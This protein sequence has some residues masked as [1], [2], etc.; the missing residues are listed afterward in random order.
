MKS[1]KIILRKLTKLIAIFLV[2]SFNKNIYSKSFTLEEAIEYGVSNNK[3]LKI[4]KLN[5][6]KAE[7][8]VKEAKG[9]AFPSL[10]FTT[11]YYHYIQKPI[12][13]FPDF[14]AL[15]N[16]STY[17]ILFKEGLVQQDNTKLLPMGMIK[18]SF[19]LN[20]QFESK[21]QLNQI[22]FNS[23]VFRGIGASKIYLELSK[24][25]YQ[26]TLSKTIANIKKAFYAC[27][28]L[29]NVAEIY[30]QSLRNAED[31]FSMIK[32]LFNQG[33]VS[34]YDLLQAE[35][36]VENL[37]P[38]V[39]NSFN[40]YQNSL[41]NLKLLLDYPIEDT[42][43]VI[44]ELKYVDFELP[45]K[46]KA[47]ERALQSN[48]DLKV[49]EYKKKVDVEMV[50]LY[51]SENYPSLVAFSNFS[52]AGQSDKLNFQT[53]TQSMVGLQLSMNLFNGFQTRSR[54]KQSIINYKETE[55]QVSQYRAYLTKLLIEKFMDLEKAR[56]Q[57]LAQEKNVKRAQKAYEIALTR[58]KEGTGIQLEIKNAELDLR[59]ANLNYQQALFDF[60]IAKIDIDN[61]FGEIK[62]E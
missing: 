47:I 27:I 16:N 37:K 40:A 28:L 26:A 62:Y 39:E 14:L 31:N 46:D 36:Q 61:I 10:D 23:T 48:L 41:N 44:G 49:L 12:V 32:S 1:K 2:L 35:V 5:I 3:E 4:Q 9:H 6:E 60:I 17:G 57:I 54:I 43:D 19:V 42:L 58:F 22:L 25:N 59:Q 56:K 11:S 53:Y 30:Q 15:L 33:L 20:N 34:E 18:Q 21:V 13:F 50:E 24:Y 7:L 29:K 51:R 38:L 45:D 8:A 55:E 52:F